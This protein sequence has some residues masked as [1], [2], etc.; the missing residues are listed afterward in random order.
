M[1]IAN[2]PAPQNLIICSMCDHSFTDQRDAESLYCEVWGIDD[3]CCCCIPDGYC[4]KA[5]PR[6]TIISTKKE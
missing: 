4:Y 1:A 5:K 3:M 6:N 2:E